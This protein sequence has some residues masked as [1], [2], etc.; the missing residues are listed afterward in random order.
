M[1]VSTPWE[2][3]QKLIRSKAIKKADFSV[4]MEISRQT[5]DNWLKNE[6]SP[7]QN[8]LKKMS[9]ILD[10]LPRETYKNMDNGEPEEIYRNIVEG[11]TEYIL[12]PRTVLQEKYRLVAIEQIQKESA[13]IEAD[14]IKDQSIIDHHVEMINKLLDQIDK[15]N[16]KPSEM[17][18]VK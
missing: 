11:N 17:Q 8:D 16:S 13:K 12:I 14:K 15:L 18:K 4:K 1:A 5:L 7:D 6:T 9:E 10:G 2:T 3:V